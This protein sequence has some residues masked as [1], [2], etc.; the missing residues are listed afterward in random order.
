VKNLSQFGR[1]VQ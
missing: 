1:D